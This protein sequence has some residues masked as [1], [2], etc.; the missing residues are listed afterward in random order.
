MKLLN[1]AGLIL[2][3]ITA[4]LAHAQ[5]EPAEIADPLP[6]PKPRYA[7]EVI[8]FEH[9]D[10]SRSTQE[11]PVPPDLSQPA[12]PDGNSRP[13]LS[14]LLLDPRLGQPDFLPLAPGEKVLDLAYRRLEQLDAYRPLVHLA[15]TQQAWPRDAAEALDLTDRGLAPPG[16]SGQLT[17]YKER[18]V[19]LAVDLALESLLA[20]PASALDPAVAPAWVLPAVP[21]PAAPETARILESR[22]LRG[23]AAQ[24]FDNP[25]FGAIAQVWELKPPEEEPAE[26]A[27]STG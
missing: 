5:T 25:R 21:P 13:P 16:L 7:V 17:L 14:F 19:H 4:G 12:A 2:A 1:T 9:V 10:Q 24:Y 15:W 18:Y 6:P 22:R 27:D 8:I 20:E 23:A 26:A 11:T 3:A